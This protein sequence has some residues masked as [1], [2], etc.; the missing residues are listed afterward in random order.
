[1]LSTRVDEDIKSASD[2]TP[3]PRPRQPVVGVFVVQGSSLALPQPTA[4]VKKGSLD[5]SVA[6]NILHKMSPVRQNNTHS[7]FSVFA[8]EQVASMACARNF[9]R[10]SSKPYGVPKSR[11]V[12]KI[13][14]IHLSHRTYPGTR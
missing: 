13:V 10:I 3:P 1:M 14:E 5:V 6:H 12:S 2:T 9:A 8:C 11:G 7:L 4:L